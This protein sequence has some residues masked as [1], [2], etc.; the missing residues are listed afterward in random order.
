[1]GEF[2][3]RR[4]VE[5]QKANKAVSLS[6]PCSYIARMLTEHSIIKLEYHAGFYGLRY[7]EAAFPLIFFADGEPR[8]PTLSQLCSSRSPY[9]GT[10]GVL[11]VETMGS[12]FRNQT[13]AKN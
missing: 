2:K 6:I 9:P 8:K 3:F 4:F 5:D 12:F 1:M 13:F 11:S 10:D 7:G